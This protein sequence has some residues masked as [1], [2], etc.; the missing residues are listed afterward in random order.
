MYFFLESASRMYRL[1]CRVGCNTAAVVRDGCE[2]YS[3]LADGVRYGHSLAL[4]DIGT[5]INRGPGLAQHCLTVGH[6]QDKAVCHFVLCNS[7]ATVKY[8]HTL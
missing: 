2:L 8:L 3:G 4:C 6:Q 5:N 7:V 1:G